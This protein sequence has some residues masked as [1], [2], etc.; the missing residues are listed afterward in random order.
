[1]V[2]Y[3][4]CN[5]KKSKFAIKVAA[6]ISTNSRIELS[7]RLLVC[8]SGGA[9]S[10]C[11]LQVLRELGYECVAAHCNFGLRGEES[12]LDEA[13]VEQLCKNMG[14]ELV[15]IRFDVDYYMA[16]HK[17]ESIEMACRA[18]RYDWFFQQA[19]QQGCSFIAVGHNFDDR[20]ET[21]ILNMLRGSGVKGLA[22]IKYKNGNIIR[23]LLDVRRSEI[24]EYLKEI[25]LTYRIDSTN[26]ANDYERNKVRNL[27]LPYIKQLF[28]DN[29]LTRTVNNMAD[30]CVFYEDAIDHRIREYMKSDGPVVVIDIESVKENPGW[31]T[32]LHEMLQ[33][34]GF[35]TSQAETIAESGQGA[36]ILSA[37]Y[38]VENDRGKLLISKINE[39]NQEEYKFRITEHADI[40]KYPIGL[41]VKR[42]RCEKG[43][44]FTRDNKKL[45]LSEEIIGKE[46]IL[47]HW[48]K[49]DV[50]Y[51]Y[52]MRGRKRLISDLFNDAKI[53]PVDKRAIW[54]LE[55]EGKILWVAGV[56]ASQYYSVREDSDMI[57]ITLPSL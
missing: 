56:R 2:Y 24:E 16:Q 22:S 3:Y 37:E 6:T 28:P 44:K 12:D 33:K 10:V 31:R 20:E 36:Q 48:R 45:Y 17:G 13:F 29:A 11:L 15:K 53:S 25:G 47:R 55:C 8:V 52:G 46:L 18:L 50:I 42:E 51:P 54:I 34:Y 35:N 57:V 23:P 14:V 38:R 21:F 5:M 49:G 7:D 39:S 27:L 32:L 40:D 1:M 26:L 9:D 4:F 30:A 19:K 43:Y 41:I